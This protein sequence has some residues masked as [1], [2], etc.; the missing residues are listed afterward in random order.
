[1]SKNKNGKVSKVNENENPPVSGEPTF[2]ATKP[3]L[4]IG[5]V[6][7][8]GTPIPDVCQLIKQELASF[9]YSVHIIKVSSILNFVKNVKGNLD[10]SDEYRRIETHMTAG[11]QI[12]ADTSRGDILA[13]L[14]IPKIWKLREEE[15]VRRGRE[16]DELTEPADGT[17]YIIN[18]IKNPD[19][20]NLFR[21]IY[22]N[23]FVLISAY[24]PKESRLSRLALI[25]NTVKT[26]K[27][28]S[29]GTLSLK[30]LDRDHS[31]E[32]VGDFGQRVSDSFALSDLVVDTREMKQC[33]VSIRRFFECFFG[34]PFHSPT[35]DEY[36]MYL[37]KGAALRSLD[38]S[39]QVGSCILDEDGSLLAQGHNDIPKAGGGLY[40]E[41]DLEDGRDYSIGKD[42]SVEFRRQIVEEIVHGLSERDIINREWKKKPEDLV[43]YLYRGEGKEIWS[44]FMVSNLL[45]F[46]RPLHAEMSAILDGSKKGNSLLGATLYCTTFPCHLC[47]R[48]I[49][50]AGIKRVVYMEPY[51]KSKTELMYQ[52]SISVDA[53]SKIPEKVNFT[54][55]VGIA[56][57]KFE[58]LFSWTGKRRQPNG[59]PLE[60]EPLESTPR[61]KRYVNTYIE[62]EAQCVLHTEKIL[63]A[64]KITIT[65]GWM[66]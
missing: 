22:G 47:A 6:G 28:D 35:K 31:E 39:R 29:P 48:L 52:D 63:K 33:Q 64:S 25:L 5:I 38:M 57:G 16:N 14:T 19:E 34:Y 13:R 49:I 65:E 4:V 53:K 9:D 62:I 44:D 10:F 23:G 60:W 55:F 37:A 20:I 50:G 17:A 36:G 58:K 12:R 18:S 11:S 56:P 26:G 8:L 54:P 51:H 61:I 30:L 21:N 32:N 24:E 59:K 3:E 40:W 15:N 7:P 42:Y 1:M 41:D 43:E 27:G 45:E 66:G 46:G 2:S